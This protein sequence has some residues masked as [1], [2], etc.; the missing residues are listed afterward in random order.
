MDKIYSL[1]EASGYLRVAVRTLRYWAQIGKIKA[2]KTAGHGKWFITE[3]E[4]KRL[5]NAE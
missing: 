2:V 1:R 3:T 4:L 5:Q